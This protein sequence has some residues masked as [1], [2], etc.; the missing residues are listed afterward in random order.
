MVDE[1]RDIFR[2]YINLC[3]VL[4]VAEVDIFCPV[5]RLIDAVF[6]YKMQVQAWLCPD[7]K[8]LI[9]ITREH[10]R[11]LPGIYLELTGNQIGLHSDTTRTVRAT[12]VEAAV[13]Y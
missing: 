12:I 6:R 13:N 1:I 4:T 11:N 3:V 7:D 5:L 8:G 9:L 2:F 10:S